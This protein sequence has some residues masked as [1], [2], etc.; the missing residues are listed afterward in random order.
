MAH[1]GPLHF[2]SQCGSVTMN[3]VIPACLVGT[4][5]VGHQPGYDRCWTLKVNVHHT[6]LI[7]LRSFWCCT[8]W[9]D[10]RSML[11]VACIISGVATT[12]QRGLS[13]AGL[14]ECRGPALHA[15]HQGQLLP[16]RVILKKKYLYCC[17]LFNVYNQSLW[18]VFCYFCY[19]KY[20][21]VQH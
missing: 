18:I 16:L 6:W 17:S 4:Q 1:W 19:Y 15:W 8:T 2:V 13:K 14:L 20:L 9:R 3:S 10:S 5:S 11:R 12:F 21:S 7:G